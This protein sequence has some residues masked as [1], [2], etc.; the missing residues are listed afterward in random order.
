[1][2]FAWTPAAL[3]DL[4]RLYVR[5]NL[6]ARQTAQALGGGVTRSA[7]LGKTQRLGWTREQ[8]PKPGPRPS[9]EGPRVNPRLVNPP[10]RWARGGPFSKVLPLPKLREI[11]VISTPKPWTER[12]E[13][14]CAFPVGEPREPGGQWSC[15]APVQ[16]RRAY[17]PA[18]WKLMTLEEPV[19][20]RQEVEIIAAIARRA[21]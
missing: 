19:L 12:G 8:R 1:M 18:H 2:P 4:H 3:D 6:S 15:C 14:E 21:A 16:R 10:P 17:C 7:V 5:E 9:P 11:T 13:R 20:T